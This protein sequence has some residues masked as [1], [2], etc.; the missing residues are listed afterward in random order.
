VTLDSLTTVRRSEDRQDEREGIP[1]VL[2]LV[3]EVGAPPHALD[4][5]AMRAGARIAGELDA[6][7][8]ELAPTQRDD[9]MG[10]VQVL[11]RAAAFEDFTDE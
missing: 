11:L 6:L 9:D 8:S 3:S 4:P 5:D 7:R 10:C 2:A 1:M